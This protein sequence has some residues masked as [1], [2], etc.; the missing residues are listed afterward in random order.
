[1]LDD[2]GRP[3]GYGQNSPF[4]D[5]PQAPGKVPQSNTPSG[6]SGHA[7]PNVPTDPTMAGWRQPSNDRGLGMPH[8]AQAQ[9]GGIGSPLQSAISGQSSPAATGQLAPVG[10]QSDLQKTQAL[11]NKYH[12]TDPASYWMGI[13]GQHGGFDS[14]GADWLEGRIARGDGAEL[15][16]RGLVSRVPSGQKQRLPQQSSLS[17]AINPPQGNP[18]DQTGSANPLLNAIRAS[19][20]KQQVTA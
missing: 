19:L 9:M 1:M 16:K 7:I 12:S 8:E 18:L 17:S 11:L 3:P 10:P 14:T 6:T 2:S 20:Q 5:A 4:Q 13:E 15:V